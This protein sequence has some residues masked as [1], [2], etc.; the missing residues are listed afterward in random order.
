MSDH[1]E[2]GEH[3]RRYRAWTPEQKRQ[4]VERLYALWLAHPAPRLGQIL[5][6]A[7]SHAALYNVEDA[8]LLATL[9]RRY[10][11]RE[12]VVGPMLEEA[13]DR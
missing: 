2:P 12:E 10:T 8:D 3:A 5:A 6:N 13:R 9:E 11:P 1:F 4:I 7:Y